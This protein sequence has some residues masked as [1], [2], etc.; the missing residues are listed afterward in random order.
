MPH[1]IQFHIE[2]GGAAGM[3]RVRRSLVL[4]QALWAKGATCFINF[5][6]PVGNDLCYDFGFFPEEAPQL[7]D[8]D[9]NIIDACPA[10]RD[11]CLD[12]YDTKACVIDDIGIHPCQADIVVNPNLYSDMLSYNGYVINYILDNKDHHLVDA[13]FFAKSGAAQIRDQILVSFGGIDI[14]QFA[15]PI[16]R[17]LM[18]KTDLKIVWAKAN[19]EP[20]PPMLTKWIDS[21]DQVTMIEMAD[22]PS[23]LQ[24]SSL[25][26]GA[27]GTTS[28]EALAA[29]AKIT[30]CSV[31]NDQYQ[32]MKCLNDMGYAAIENLNPEMMVTLGLNVMDDV[33]S[34]APITKEGPSLIAE[35][36]T[37]YLK[38]EITS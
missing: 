9:L 29:G 34:D 23:E 17:T 7:S 36:I 38:G 21:T 3:G 15:G 35:E 13:A 30:V 8:I 18:T 33:H 1:N 20:L 4:A 28:L 25:Y 16:I 2:C 26:I 11:Q 37:K 27:A 10:Y 14:G 19:T 5:T 31:V 6:D 12:T 24:K 22:M 32:N